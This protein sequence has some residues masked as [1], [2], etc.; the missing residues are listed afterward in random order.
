MTTIYERLTKIPIAGEILRILN[1]Y[2]YNGDHRSDYYFAGIR[3]W[4]KCYLPNFLIALLS[5]LACT[6]DITN[7]FIPFNYRLSYSIESS[8]GPLATSILP[9]LLGFGIG[10]YALIFGLKTTFIMRFQK[11][12]EESTKTKHGSSLILNVSFAVPLLCLA[13]AIIIGIIQSLLPDNPYLRVLS[14]FSLWLSLLFTIETIFA[15]FNLGEAHILTV[16]NTELEARVKENPKRD[17]ELK[18]K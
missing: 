14:W 12:I 1:N 17:E 9:N 3:L 8:P 13:L 2:A 7:L 4:A 15:I 18:E 6:P 5:A 10:V 16:E 11:Q